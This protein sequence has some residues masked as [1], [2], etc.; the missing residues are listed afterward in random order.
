MSFSTLKLSQKL[1]SALPLNITVPSEIQLQAIPP[2][3][4]GHDILALAQTGSG[5][6]LAYGLPLLDIMDV[7]NRAVQAIIIVP[8][9]E[10]AC[11]VERSLS[12]L[13]NQLQLTTALLIGGVDLQPQIDSLTNGVHI[14]IATPGRLIDIMLSQNISMA[15]LK[16]C[17]LDEA[18]RLQ[19]MGFWSDIN[20]ILSKLP[21]ARQNLLFSATLPEE[22]ETTLTSV[23]NHPIRIEVH[24]RNAYVEQIDT[25]L[26]LV[27]KGSKAAA[28]IHLIKQ[29]QWSQVL[30]FINARD[31]ADALAKKLAKHGINAASLHGNKDQI[32]REQRLEGFKTQQIQVLVTTDMLARGIHIEQ[33]P[34]V[35]NFELPENTSTYIHRVGRTARNGKQGS[36]ISLVCHSETPQLNALRKFTQQPLPLQTLSQFPVTDQ[37]SSG[38]NKRPTRDKQA[39]RRNG[40]RMR[41]ELIKK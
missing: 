33:L 37:P 27:N 10:L 3:L 35:I 2:I 24:N 22:I 38:E 9:R 6:T 17:V 1:L 23:L 19:E 26:Y 4:E 36:A 34:V 15:H 28:L 5:K 32:E 25:Q 18:D 20:R 8:T 11:Q 21:D 41:T 14:V 31:N 29:Q 40:K 16:I 7:N 13:A 39:N 12:P 30:V